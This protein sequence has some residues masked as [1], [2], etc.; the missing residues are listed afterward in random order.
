MMLYFCT[1]QRAQKS[2]NNNKILQLH[3]VKYLDL[4]DEIID[5]NITVLEDYFSEDAWQHIQQT[6]T[7]QLL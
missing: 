3:E 6:G 1:K 4:P 7:Y 5:D 2:I